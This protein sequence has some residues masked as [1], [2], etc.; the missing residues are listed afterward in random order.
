M[1]FAGAVSPFLAVTVSASE[2]QYP[3]SGTFENSSVSE[4]YL[5]GNVRKNDQ[6]AC[7]RCHNLKKVTIEN[8]LCQIDDSK[9]TFTNV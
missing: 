9:Y 1:L 2:K 8:P 4:L 5:S 6:G 7:N 3:T